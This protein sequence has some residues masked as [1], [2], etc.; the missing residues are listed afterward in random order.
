MAASGCYKKNPGVVKIYHLLCVPPTLKR[1]QQYFPARDKKKRFT[2]S[3]ALTPKELEL[4]I[5]HKIKSDYI[6][7]CLSH[8]ISNGVP[9]IE[10]IPVHFGVLS[11]SF[12][13]NGISIFEFFLLIVSHFENRQ[14]PC[15][16]TTEF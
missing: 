14:F 12:H 8:F 1:C 6:G 13:S 16:V 4:D 7:L 10:D 3:N 5:I 2:L 15:K 9:S 11:I